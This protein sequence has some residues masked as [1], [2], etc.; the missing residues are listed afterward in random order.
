MRLL[1]TGATLL[2]LFAFW[3]ERKGFEPRDKLSEYGFFEG[4]L[5]D[6]NPAEG[7]LLYDLNTPLF[8][9]YAEK[10]R[11]IRLPEGSQFTYRDSSVFEFPVGTILIK[12]FYYPNDFRKP[13]KGRQ[14]IETRLLVHESDGWQAYPYIWN[15]EQ[16]EAFL[17][18]AG[19]TK[20]IRY[21]NS[22]GKKITTQYVIPNKNQCKGCH[23]QNKK[24]LPLGPNARQ[25]NRLNPESKQNQ[26]QEWS[27][28]GILQGFPL[29]SAVPKVAVW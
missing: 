19:E 6:L 15:G 22:S 21:I 25:L 13:E 28:S 11:F 12:N 4:N 7:V 14:I 8:S 23:I 24:I 3:T 5:A 1:L 9:N 16:S 26:L 27:A 2:F 29:L 20:T 10:L 18:V 17:D